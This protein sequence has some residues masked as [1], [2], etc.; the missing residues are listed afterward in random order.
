MSRATRLMKH[1]DRALAAY[2]TFGDSAEA[3]VDEVYAA[4]EADV[5]SL[6]DKSK[7]SHW[8]ELYVERDR[9]VIKQAVLNRVMSMGSHAQA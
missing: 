1:L 3:F 2:D 7:P 9:A 6:A 5:E 8:A 4:I